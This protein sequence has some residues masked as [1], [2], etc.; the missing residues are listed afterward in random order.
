MPPGIWLVTNRSTS[1]TTQFH[2]DDVQ[3]TDHRAWCPLFLA[4]AV[5]IALDDYPCRMREVESIRSLLRGLDRHDAD[6]GALSIRDAELLESFGIGTIRWASVAVVRATNA[7]DAEIRDPLAP[8]PAIQTVASRVLTS[9]LLD[10]ASVNREPTKPQDFDR[11][12]VDDVVAR[13]VELSKV[14]RGLRAMQQVWLE[15]LITDISASTAQLELPGI[16]TRFTRTI[17]IWLAAIVEAI[18]AERHRLELSEQSRIRAVVEKLLSGIPITKKEASQLT[19]SGLAGWHTC[20]VLGMR[21]NGPAARQDLDSFARLFQKITNPEDLLRFEMKTGT[22]CLWSMSEHPARITQLPPIE[23]SGSVA[24][25]IGK[26]HRG[27]AGFRRTY[28]EA[29][30]AYRLAATGFANY[31]V[32]YATNALAIML[33]QDEE[34]AQWFIDATLG[35]LRTNPTEWDEARETIRGFF[36]A[37]MRVAPAAA[38]LH[39]HRNTMIHRLERIER[40]LG[41]RLAERSAEVQAALLLSEVRFDDA[42]GQL[43]PPSYDPAGFEAPNADSTPHQHPQPI[44]LDR[45]A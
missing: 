43:H 16:I 1:A 29:S 33:A 23:G 2:L 6:T 31:A 35:A 8:A 41:F 28:L 9:A 44:N 25:G 3:V 30:D 27:E 32:S 26:S 11:A 42:A 4:L 38:T 21:S 36:D 37:R 12:I 13:G 19:G 17:D 40:S 39:I 10:L 34:R 22:I 24:A 45:L 5:H 18:T 15:Q 7:V 20:C 14:T